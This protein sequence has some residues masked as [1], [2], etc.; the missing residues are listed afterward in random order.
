MGDLTK[1]FSWSEFECKCGLCGEYSMDIQFVN[2]LQRMREAYGRGITISSGFRCKLHNE[3]IGGVSTSSHLKGVAADIS[4]A[5]S[6]DRHDLILAALEAG[7]SRIGIAES[8]IHVDLDTSKS[9]RVI[10][11]Y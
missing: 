6:R 10:W 7:F 8:Y 5:G 2:R 3:L 4:Y 11:L 9:Q 1:N